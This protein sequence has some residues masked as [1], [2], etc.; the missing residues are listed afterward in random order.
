MAS[1]EGL[2]KTTQEAIRNSPLRGRSL[3]IVPYDE[4][5]GLYDSLRPKTAP[6]PNDGSLRDLK[7]NATAADS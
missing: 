7:I 4:H 5:G 3:L 6:Q 2:I 1:G